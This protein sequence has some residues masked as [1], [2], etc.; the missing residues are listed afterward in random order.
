M[1]FNEIFQIF[2]RPGFL[3]LFFFS[4]FVNIFVIGF[5]RNVFTQ[6]FGWSWGYKITRI[7]TVVTEVWTKHYGMMMMMKSTKRNL[8]KRYYLRGFI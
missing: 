6:A 4:F 8:F 2:P 3:F 7:Y 5:N 1:E